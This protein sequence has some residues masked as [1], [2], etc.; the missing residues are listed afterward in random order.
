MFIPFFSAIGIAQLLQFSRNQPKPLKYTY[1]PDIKDIQVHKF[2]FWRS[3]FYLFIAFLIEWQVILGYDLRPQQCVLLSI[4]S[5]GCRNNHIHTQTLV[6][7]TW[8]PNG[9][10]LHMVPSTMCLAHTYPC[11]FAGQM[12]FSFFKKWNARLCSI[13]YRIPK[14]SWFWLVCKSK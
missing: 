4:P 1:I 12:I 2:Q 8:N 6:S 13:W 7:C 11:A 9:G 5:W 10:V 14:T 3:R